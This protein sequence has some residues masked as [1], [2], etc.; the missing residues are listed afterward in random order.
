MYQCC[1]KD[2]TPRPFPKMITVLSKIVHLAVLTIIPLVLQYLDPTGKK[3][4]Q[5]QICDGTPLLCNAFAF[6][7]YWLCRWYSAS[8]KYTY[9]NREISTLNGGFLKL[10]D[11]FTHY[12]SSSGSS[13]ENEINTRLAK[14]RTATDRLSIIWKSERESHKNVTSFIKQIL[15]VTSY[16]TATVQQQTFNI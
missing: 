16:K 7:L 12:G 6:S 15:E 8:G 5:W 11:K 14:A 1:V 13:T 10:V 9:L 3:S 2:I 4:H